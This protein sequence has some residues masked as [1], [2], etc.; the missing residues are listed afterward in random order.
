MIARGTPGFSGADLENLVNEAALLAARATRTA[1]TWTT[2]RTPRTRSSW[3]PSARAVISERDRRV[4]AYH[5]AGHALVAKLQGRHR[6]RPQGHHHPPRPRPGRHPAAPQRGPPH[7]TRDYAIKRI[8]ILMGGRAA[9]EIIFNEITTGAGQD[10]QHG[11][12]HRPQDDLRVGH[13]RVKLGPVAYSTDRTATPSSAASGLESSLLQPSPPPVE[14][15][16]RSSDL[17]NGRVRHRSP[18]PL[19]QHGQAQDSSPRRSSSS[20]SIDAEDLQLVTE[21]GTLEVLR[22]RRVRNVAA[23][24]HRTPR[25]DFNTAAKEDAAA[26]E[27]GEAK[28]GDLKNIWPGLE[29]SES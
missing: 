27:S 10:I 13:V 12:R 20:R 9:E 26:P 24:H 23:R 11:H 25:T 18:A 28:D 22:E 2:S 4:T 16:A 8:S 14:I 7:L 17:I 6:P 29:G 15:D 1:S 5:E 3:A 19:R 21:E